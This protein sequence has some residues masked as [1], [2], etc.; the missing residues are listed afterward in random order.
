MSIMSSEPKKRNCLV[1]KRCKIYFKRSYS[2]VLYYISPQVV[3]Y[4]SLTQINFDAKNTM[5]L[6]RDLKT[7]ELPFINTKID[8]SLMDF[9]F[10]VDYD[11]TIHK[12]GHN[13]LTGQV[14]NQPVKKNQKVDMLWETGKAV[15]SETMLKTCSFDNTDCYEA[16]TVPVIFD[17][18]QK[19][20]YLTGG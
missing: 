13:R 18:S 16:R 5:H 15:K 20:S 12:D 14:G 2:P 17:I 7:D 11:Q 3:Y 4:E 8:G 6:I 9:E 10:H 1:E 19:K